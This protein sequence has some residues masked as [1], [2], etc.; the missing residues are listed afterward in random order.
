[1]DDNALVP[2]NDGTETGT[3]C[4]DEVLELPDLQESNLDCETL[5]CVLADLDDFAQVLDLKALTCNGET[6]GM[7]DIVEARD[8]FVSGRYKRLKIQYRFA[9]Q[10]WVDTVIRRK[11]EILLIRM[12][13]Q[14]R[15]KGGS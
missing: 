12:L 15:C 1:M 2:R 5:D 11:G 4:F 3:F 9:E 7:E 14:E 10:V 13:E 8:G 6:V